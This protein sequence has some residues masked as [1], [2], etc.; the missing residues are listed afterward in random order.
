MSTLKARAL[1]LEERKRQLLIEGWTAEHDDRC[2]LYALEL[3]AISY[4]DAN[5]EQ[6]AQPIYWPWDNSWWKPK[7]RQRNLE[8]AGALYLAAAD[9]SERAGDYSKRD[10]FLERAESCVVLLDSHLSSES[11]E[12]PKDT[13]KEVKR[14]FAELP[15]KPETKN[16]LNSLLQEMLQSTSEKKGWGCRYELQG[17]INAF[18]AEGVINE[19]EHEAFNEAIGALW[20]PL[21][22]SFITD[23]INRDQVSAGIQGKGRALGLEPCT[24]AED[25]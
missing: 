12:H 21:M 13:K 17:A 1:V 15:V 6:A 20:K 14:M 7:S 8:R 11:K 9:V 5:D 23:R 19:Q 25:E 16:Y 24:K 22:L 4:R 10:F 18:A 2:G 3:A